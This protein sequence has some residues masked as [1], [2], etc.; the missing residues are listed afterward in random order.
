MAFSPLRDGICIRLPR[1]HRVHGSACASHERLERVVAAL[2]DGRAELPCSPVLA[3]IAADV[4]VVHGHDACAV[5]A[6]RGK[7]PALVKAVAVEVARPVE[8]GNGEPG[9][10]KLRHL[11]GQSRLSPPRC[12]LRLK[13]AAED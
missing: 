3:L 12:I 13:Y 10:P 6:V 9:P 11:L 7:W 2:V 1:R 5:H 8:R 4:V